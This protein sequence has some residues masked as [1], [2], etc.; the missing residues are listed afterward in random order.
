MLGARGRKNLIRILKE[1]TQDF[2]SAVLPKI[3]ETIPT[4]R[5]NIKFYSIDELPLWRAHSLLTKEPETIEWIDGFEDNDVFWDIGANIG[6]YTLYAG[7][8]QNIQVFAFEPSAPN[9]MLL[10]KNIEFNNLSKSIKAFCLAFTDTTC[11]DELK[12]QNTN[13]GG[14]L[15]S[16]GVP[17][18]HNGKTFKPNF[19]QGMLGFSIDSFVEIFSLPFPT[20]IKIDVDGIED[21]IVSG[22]QKT[23]ADRRLKSLSIELDANRSEFTTKIVTNIEQAGLKL[24]SRRHATIFDDSPYA[25][26]YNYLFTRE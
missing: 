14:A 6:V 25:N 23:F 7:I 13:F 11:L 2:N 4:P 24:K 26:I 21:R 15:S 12:M 19:L 10:N 8:T 18:D 9:Y 1:A 5:G 17:I 16:F 22:A 3:I 20:H